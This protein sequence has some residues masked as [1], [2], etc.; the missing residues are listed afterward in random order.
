MTTT[1]TS[2]SESGAGDFWP[3]D[4]NLKLNLVS[5][6]ELLDT[7]SSNCY[8]KTGTSSVSTRSRSLQGHNMGHRDLVSEMEP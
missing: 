6:M 8:R 4:L 1:A 7:S 3:E 5:E 2:I